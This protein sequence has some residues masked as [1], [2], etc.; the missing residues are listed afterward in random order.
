MLFL[1][2]VGVV[3]E[4][5]WERLPFAI[6]YVAAGGVATLA[7][8]LASPDSMVPLIGASGAIAGLMGAFV[9]GHPRTKIKVFY[10]AWVIRPLVGT[11]S[12]AA[13]LLIPAWVALQIGYALLF[14]GDGVAYWAHVGGFAAGVIGALIMRWGGWVVYDAEQ[15]LGEKAESR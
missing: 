14:P 11:M 7:H 4:C 1:W 13:W 10:A 12:V 2:L 5:F 15:V 9:V 8:H 6:L 3:I